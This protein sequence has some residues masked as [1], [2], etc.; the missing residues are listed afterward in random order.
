[1]DL[2][3]RRQLLGPALRLRLCLCLCGP[4]RR[5]GP[6]DRLLLGLVP[7]PWEW[8]RFVTPH[9]SITRLESMQLA[10][11]YTFS[12]TRLGDVEHLGQDQR[13]R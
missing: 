7:V 2:V 4:A 9:A 5:P 1:M 3:A 8:D 6:P 10:D 11:G 13:T 12:L